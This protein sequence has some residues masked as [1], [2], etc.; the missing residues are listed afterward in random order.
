VL[1]NNGSPFKAHENRPLAVTDVF[2][3]IVMLLNI[4]KA[5]PKTETAYS[6]AFTIDLQCQGFYYSWK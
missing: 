3:P 4:R 6:T 1:V 5:L 2:G